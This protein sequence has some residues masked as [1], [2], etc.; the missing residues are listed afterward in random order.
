LI[1]QLFIAEAPAYC[2]NDLCLRSH[3]DSEVVVPTRFDPVHGAFQWTS[4]Q[5]ISEISGL[6]WR[7][8]HKDSTLDVLQQF[9]LSQAA[10]RFDLGS[11]T[12]K[13]HTSTASC[14]TAASYSGLTFL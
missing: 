13:P 2:C 9:L 12:P 10:T 11:G 7:M 6:L 1:E 4:L 14:L 5:V 3:A 8:V